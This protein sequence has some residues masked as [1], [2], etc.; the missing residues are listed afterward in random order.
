M[1]LYYARLNKSGSGES[2]VLI[3]AG[4]SQGNLWWARRSPIRMFFFLTRF[5]FRVVVE[6]IDGNDLAALA[7]RLDVDENPADNWRNSVD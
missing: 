1:S 3:R 2:E 6:K 4:R 7:G 5:R